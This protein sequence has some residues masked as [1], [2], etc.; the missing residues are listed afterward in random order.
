MHTND[1]LV[2]DHSPFEVEISIAELE[3]YKSSGN[4]QILADLIQ[5]KGRGLWNKEELPNQLKEAIVLSVYKVY[6]TTTDCSNYHGIA[7]L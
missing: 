1:L 2:P 3:D 6:D 7:V 4:D 5:A